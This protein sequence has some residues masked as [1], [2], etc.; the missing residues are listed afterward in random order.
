MIYFCIT[1]TFY[2]GL[3]FITICNKKLKCFLCFCLY[4]LKLKNC[5]MSTSQ[6]YSRRYS[7]HVSENSTMQPLE[8]IPM[9]FDD[10]IRIVTGRYSY[11]IQF[12][13]YMNRYVVIWTN[14]PMM[15]VNQ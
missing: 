9:N 12:S 11:D 2:T 14:N 4:Q 10:V 15:S 5:S 7:S 1:I 6:S 8:N 3:F 13:R